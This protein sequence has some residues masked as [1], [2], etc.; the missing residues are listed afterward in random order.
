VK[1]LEGHA[2]PVK[3]V[4]QRHGEP[5]PC[6]GENKPPWFANEQRRPEACG[7]DGRDELLKPLAGSAT[8]LQKMGAWKA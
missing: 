7:Q 1:V 4:V 8:R 3:S 6:F 2:Q 5:G